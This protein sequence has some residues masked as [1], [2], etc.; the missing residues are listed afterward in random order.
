MIAAVRGS[1]LYRITGAF[2][3]IQVAADRRA[4]TGRRVLHRR[5]ASA[6][7]RGATVVLDGLR[8]QAG[9]CRPPAPRGSLR[10]RLPAEYR[11]IGSLAF[12]K[13]LLERGQCRGVAGGRRRPNHG[14]GFVR[15][16]DVENS[17]RSRQ[18]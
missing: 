16:C 17:Q 10:R 1:I 12:S 4:A 5:I 7:G 15:I 14:E 18:A 8:K 13:L 9:R 3:P 6:T 2:T 11:G